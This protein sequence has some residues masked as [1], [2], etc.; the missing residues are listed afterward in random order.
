MYSFSFVVFF[1]E[2]P[3]EKRIFLLILLFICDRLKSNFFIREVPGSYLD[4]QISK[5]DTV[6]GI[7]SVCPDNYLIH[8][9]T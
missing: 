3:I 8:R 1:S 9:C 6:F 7:C 4:S 2:N 5:F